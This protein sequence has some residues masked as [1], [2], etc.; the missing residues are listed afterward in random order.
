MPRW[1]PPRGAAHE[2]L[3]ICSCVLL[4]ALA[5]G[6]ANAQQCSVGPRIPFAGHA[7]PLSGEATPTSLEI[8]RVY[9]NV[10]LDQP[11]Q[12]VSPPDGTGRLFVVEKTGRIRILPAD[13]SSASAPVF[14]DLSASIVTQDAEGLLGLVFDP[15]YATNRRFYVDYTAPGGD[16]QSGAPCMKLV[17]F[18]ARSGNPSQADPSSKL[19]LLEITRNETVHNGGMLAFGPDGM[20]YASEGDDGG[21][22]DLAKLTGKLLRLDVRGSSYAIPAD[23]PFTGQAGRRGE[24]WAYGLRNPWRF[25]FDK[26][27]GDLWIGDVGQASWEEVDYLP[28][29]TPAGVNF[30]WPYCEGTHDGIIGTCASIASRP[31]LL[32]YPHDLS[33]GLTVIGGYVY[34]GSSVPSLYGSYLYADWAF[35]KL[36]MRP[37]PAGPSVEVANPSMIASFGEANDGELYLVAITG[38]LYQLGEPGPDTDGDGRQDAIDNCLTVANPD[39]AD[40][41]GDGVGD[42]CDNCVNLANPRVTPDAATYLGA[43]PWATLTGGQRD[44]D[45][46]G[47]GN[48][49]D[50]KFPGVPGLF[51]S[52]GD[53]IEWR[54]SNT[55]NRTVDQCGTVGTHPCAIYDLDETGL[56]ISNGDLLQWRL[57]NTKAPGPKCP[58]CPLTCTAGT[59]GT[60]GAIP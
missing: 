15:A 60:C 8:I 33:G 36:W 43:N 12:L 16:C 7:L 24:I 35:A 59:A 4:L 58:T 22:Q 11:L 46:D 56:F 49:C 14:L 44:D 21:A 45:H 28:A 27:T 19:E 2:G 41:D 55:K 40:T 10:A 39:Q 18:L 32:E 6:S 47:Y 20:L 1:F 30:G 3:L 48:K 9:P 38:E 29:G 23:N 25:S 13:P 42:V 53:L 57:L 54:A 50:G 5:S 26:L 51:V 34:R 17:R 37:T 31:P 52:N